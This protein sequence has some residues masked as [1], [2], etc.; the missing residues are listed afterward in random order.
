MIH[1]WLKRFLMQN[2]DSLWYRLKNDSLWYR[3][4]NTFTNTYKEY[5][6]E[7]EMVS[8][9]SPSGKEYSDIMLYKIILCLQCR[10]KNIISAY[11][12]IHQPHGWLLI[13]YFLNSQFFKQNR[14]LLCRWKNSNTTTEHKYILYS[15][16]HQMLQ[17]AGSSSQNN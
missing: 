4:K 1:L 13:I 9:C 10:G 16:Y 14:I 12:F 3:L 11:S 6:C 17:K 15:I 5:T 7:V 8:H 2:N